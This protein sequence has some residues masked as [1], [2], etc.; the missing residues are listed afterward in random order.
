MI[1]ADY[2]RARERLDW[3]R[4]R[5]FARHV[6]EEGRTLVLDHGRRVERATV[7][8]HGLSASPRQFLAVAQELHARGHNVFVPRLP[9][10]GHKNRLSE[11]LATLSMAQLEAC[12]N[13]SLAI[14]RGFGSFVTVA[15]F[16]LGGLLA[17][18]LGQFEHVQRVVAVSP[19]LGVAFIPNLLRLPLAHW[20]LRRPNRFYWW[21]PFRRE[22]QLP[23]HGYPRYATH[24]VA[25]GLTLAHTVME[26]AKIS[27]PRAEELVLVVNPRDSAVNNRAIL[28]LGERWIQNKPGSVHVRRLAGVPPFLHDIIEPKRYPDVAKRVLPIVVELID[29]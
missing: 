6:A 7:L 27:P 23:E 22:R 8:F 10:H 21:D 12:A 4:R 26:A 17:A 13:D 1:D 14:A 24:A 2:D 20:V 9:R 3:F 15:G 28:R 11:A 29:S 18:Y 25:H 19:F 5:D 16:S